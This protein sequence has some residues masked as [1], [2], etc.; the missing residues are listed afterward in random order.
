MTDDELFQAIRAR[1]IVDTHYHVGPELVDRRY[2]VA[3]L[4]EAAR[5]CGITLVLK[6]HTYPTTPLAALAR[7]R[8]GVRFLGSVVLNRFVGGLNPDAV[9]GAASGNR[10]RVAEPGQDPAFV[11]YMPTVH[12][13]SHLR[14]LGAAFDPRWSCGH[15]HADHGD[16]TGQPVAVFDA[17]LRPLPALQ[18]VLE[19]I[20]ATGAILA[21][22]HLCAAEIMRLVPLALAAGIG[23]VL[24]THPHYPSVE[25][26]DDQLQALA[27]DPRV[28]IEHCFAIHTIEDVPLDRFARSIRA[29][30]TRQVV[31]ST[32]FGQVHSDPVPDGT[33]RFLRELRRELGEAV[34]AEELIAMFTSNGERALGLDG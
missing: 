1:G 17:E 11:V 23:R 27:A 4:A 29:T 22:G 2:D 25:L 8:F 6:N 31:L 13:E 7:A 16:E 30:G 5:G 26:A 12:A 34:P 33:A 19:A 20:A 32:D 24:L 15:A 9:F 21:T 10:S 18:P 28:F 3:S 14:V